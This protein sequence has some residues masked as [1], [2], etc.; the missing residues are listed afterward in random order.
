MF[1]HKP[2]H[3]DDAFRTGDQAKESQFRIINHHFQKTEKRRMIFYIEEVQFEEAIYS[4][5]SSCIFDEL[6]E[7]YAFLNVWAVSYVEAE[8]PV[9]RYYYKPKRAI[10]LS[11][12]LFDKIQKMMFILT[13]LQHRIQEVEHDHDKLDKCKSELSEQGILDIICRCIEMIYYK[14]TPPSMFQRSFKSSKGQGNM[15]SNDKKDDEG[16][17]I[18]S[19][20]VDLHKIR[21]D[22]YVA[23]EIARD[24]LDIVAMRLLELVLALARGHR[25]NSEKLTKYYGIF[26]QW[27]QVQQDYFRLTQINANFVASNPGI[28]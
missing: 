2:K 8:E 20:Q 4:Y 26:Y 22:E 1:E 6:L 11:D 28:F 19:A 25:K 9:E 13:N 7:F 17:P 23:Q 15:A 5:Q 3:V 18:G 14:T 10:D 16:Q 21:I 24:H 12:E 27:F